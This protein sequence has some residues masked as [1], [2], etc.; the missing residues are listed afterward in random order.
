MLNIHM[1]MLKE[2]AQIRLDT[3]MYNNKLHNSHVQYWI[4]SNSMMK[5]AKRK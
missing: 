2:D 4:K 5:Y 1:K 3:K